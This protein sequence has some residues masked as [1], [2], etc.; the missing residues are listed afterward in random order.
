VFVY[1]GMVP[2]TK[3]FADQLELDELGYIITDERQHTN[4]PGVFAAGD[5]QSPDFRQIVIAAASGAKA[6]MEVDRFL[7]ESA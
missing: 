6:V 2:G 4:V 7:A 1:I 3:W 5:V